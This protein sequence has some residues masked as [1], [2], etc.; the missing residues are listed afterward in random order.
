[1]GVDARSDRHQNPHRIT[2]RRI[3]MV[4]RSRFTSHSLAALGLLAACG[5]SNVDNASPRV[6]DVPLMATTG[7]T[8]FSLDLEDYVT[9][10][11]GAT[12]TYAVT[13]GGG[14]FAGSTYSHTFP[15]MGEFTVEFTVTDGR[16]TTD[17]SFEVR[18]TSANLAVVKE[19]TGGLLLL[20]TATNEFVR[21]AASATTPTVAAGLADG[22][23][24]YHLAGSG[25]GQQLWLFD[26]MTRVN[27][28]L[29]VGTTG[30]VAYRA[31]TSDSRIVYTAGTAP[32]LLIV[33]Y[34]PTTGVAR[35][36]TA[37]GLA[38]IDVLV[39]GDDLVF[40]EVGVDGQADVYAYDP[41]EDES[42]SI[43]TDTRD[44]QLLAV[45]PN[46]GVVFSRIGAGGE[47]DLFYWKLGTGL[48]EIGADVTALATQNKTYNAHGSGSQ[49]VFTALDGTDT[50]LWFWNPGTGQTTNIS[51]DE[52]DTFRAIAAGN[53]VVFTREVT[54]TDHDVKFY[55]LDTGDAAD[56][57]DGADIGTL[58]SVTGDGTLNWAIVRRSGATSSLLAVSIEDSPTTETWAAGS[59]V[60]TTVGV[61]DNGD[62]VG[63]HADGTA[64]N[65]FD[66]SVGTWGTPITGAGLAFAG[67]G[68]AAGDFVYTVTASSQVDLAMWDASGT[69]SVV[70]SDT[71]GAD[72]FAARTAD[73]TI[74]FTRVVTGNSNTDLFVWDGT[75]ETR[76]TDEDN[77]ALQ[78]DHVVLGQYTGTR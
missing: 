40:Y 76:L 57:Y 38:T 28:Q 67:D 73:G 4:H 39:N 70:V 71:A 13:S 31:K 53:E 52:P 78:F 64:L 7:G 77:A 30:D 60:A 1:V 33:Y 55:D 19:G 72:A 21:L 61:L 18:V 16:K 24:A 48:V 42:F 63:R 3:V 15:T 44:E 2:E 32:D 6:S 49:V 58:V 66:V 69:T 34:N 10:R 8:A 68:L 5:G 20:D 65:V 74:L 35:E 22:R 47:T 62:V 54:S 17:A 9:D 26:P 59:A 14:S 45:L 56:L 25:G 36:L 46:D 41:D 50:E 75:A 23:L 27:T 51:A 11:E 12:L 43:G 29:G 37:G